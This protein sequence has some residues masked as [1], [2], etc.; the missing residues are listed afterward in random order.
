M[1][2][3]L[4]TISFSALVHESE[5]EKLA[6]DFRASSEQ[7]QVAQI[8][9]QNWAGDGRLTTTIEVTDPQK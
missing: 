4:V 5:A 7:N 9:V 1:S 2:A 3:K 6:E 8:A